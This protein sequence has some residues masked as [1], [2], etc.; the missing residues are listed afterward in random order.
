MLKSATNTCMA[1][2]AL[3]R[4]F[5]PSVRKGVTYAHEANLR[6]G[7]IGFFH[8]YLAFADGSVIVSVANRPGLLNAKEANNQL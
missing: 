4:R 1:P 2:M 6:V 3:I 7:N 5:Q 8:L